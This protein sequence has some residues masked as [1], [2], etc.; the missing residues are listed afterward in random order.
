MQYELNIDLDDELFLDSLWPFAS[1]LNIV[2]RTAHSPKDKRKNDSTRKRQ[3]GER[4][5]ND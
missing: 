1:S 5:E 2:D 3:T 4:I